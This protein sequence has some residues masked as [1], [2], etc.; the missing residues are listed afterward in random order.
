MA[1]RSNVMSWSS[2][3]SGVTSPNQWGDIAFVHISRLASAIESDPS[4]VEE[5]SRSVCIR[6]LGGLTAKELVG[7]GNADLVTGFLRA[8]QRGE[9]D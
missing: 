4:R 1:T 8:V 5:W 3:K 7:Q 6:E 2:R 9:R